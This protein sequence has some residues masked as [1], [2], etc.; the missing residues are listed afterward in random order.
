VRAAWLSLSLGCSQCSAAFWTPGVLG[1]RLQKSPG[2]VQR[3]RRTNSRGVCTHK[4]QATS[5]ASWQS[6]DRSTTRR[7]KNCPRLQTAQDRNCSF[8]ITRDTVL[9]AYRVKKT[10]SR[11][12]VRRTKGTLSLG[13]TSFGRLVQGFPGATRQ[14]RRPENIGFR[15]ESSFPMSVPSGVSRGETPRVADHCF[16]LDVARMRCDCLAQC[17]SAGVRE[18]KDSRPITA[19]LELDGRNTLKNQGV[20]GGVI[21]R[22]GTRR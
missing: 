6:T 21:P 19:G 1:H 2:S 16:R 8:S 20:T 15:Y 22:V 5:P 11:K 18:K 12:C 13:T 14:D 7:R 9:G 10:S 4:A 17:S 3:V